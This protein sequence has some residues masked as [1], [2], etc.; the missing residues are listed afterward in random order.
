MSVLWSE[1]FGGGDG[2]EGEDDGVVDAGVDVEEEES[3]EA[4]LK[5]LIWQKDDGGDFL[6]PSNNV[7]VLEIAVHRMILV[8]RDIVCLG[9]F[10]DMICL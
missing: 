7:V 8:L 9:L 10:V 2:V 5:L 6:L 4:A 1:S 3:V